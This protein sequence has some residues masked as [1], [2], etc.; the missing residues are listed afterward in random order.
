MARQKEKERLE[1]EERDQII[2]ERKR[3]EKETRELLLIKQ[4]EREAAQGKIEKA[5]RFYTTKCLLNYGLKPLQKFVTVQK[6][7]QLD[8]CIFHRRAILKGALRVMK[9]QIK[10]KEAA[11]NATADTFCQS[12]TLRLY[13]SLLQ[14][15][16]FSLF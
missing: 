8:A 11:R 10:D 9:R 6:Q 3:L 12:I 2:A 1:M 15:V 5:K 4:K 14:N 16:S 7:L 13:Y